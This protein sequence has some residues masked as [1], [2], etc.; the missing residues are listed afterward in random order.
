M[1]DMTDFRTLLKIG[2]SKSYGA[3]RGIS[4]RNTR[5][6]T[7]VRGTVRFGFND[8]GDF[9]VQI[10]V[11]KPGEVGIEEFSKIIK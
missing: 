1:G 10:D 9:V 4:R 7:I 11:D 3:L 2:S 5:E 6:L 8:S